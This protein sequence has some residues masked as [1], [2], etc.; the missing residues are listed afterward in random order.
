MP[1]KS[2]THVWG[3]PQP[4]SYFLRWCLSSGW[5]QGARAVDA[6]F[7]AAA[8][9]ASSRK[10]RQSD[11]F[12]QSPRPRL[13]RLCQILHWFASRW[14]PPTP[15]YDNS[16]SKLTS[17]CFQ[18]THT[19]NSTK[20]T[21]KNNVTLHLSST[22]IDKRRVKWGWKTLQYG[23]SQHGLNSAQM[24]IYSWRVIHFL[25]CFPSTE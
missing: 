16:H 9:A 1:T 4:S 17:S 3:R 23:V 25:R 18:N 5:C 20:N 13:T 7:V 10:Q 14:L 19:T 24:T 8:I 21:N 22:G 15:S 11:F 2:A 12:E 6:A